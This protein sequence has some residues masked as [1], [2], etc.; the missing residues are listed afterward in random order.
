MNTVASSIAINADRLTKKFGSRIV[1]NNLC[2]EIAEGESVAI[3]G[4]NG[5]GQNHLIAMSG[6]SDAHSTAVNCAGSALQ[7]PTNPHC[8]VCW[9]W[10]PTTDF[11]IR[12]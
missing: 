2:L 5:S 12:I 8:G 4:A 11:S 3:A 1:L 10:S 6:R 7:P 9:E